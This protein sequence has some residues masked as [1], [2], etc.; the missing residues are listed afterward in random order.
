MVALKSTPTH[1]MLDD[2][3]IGHQ[4]EQNLTMLGMPDNSLDALESDQLSQS[5][6]SIALV[7]LVPGP[8]QANCIRW[9]MEHFVT[10][11]DVNYCYSWQDTYV[12]SY[13][14]ALAMRLAGHIELSDGLIAALKVNRNDFALTETHTFGGVINALDRH[15]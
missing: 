5:P 6:C 1:G 2:A 7:A 3:F 11:T 4:T 10:A 14:T 12:C 9:L 15:A 8:Q 13:A